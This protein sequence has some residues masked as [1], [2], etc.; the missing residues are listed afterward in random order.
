MEV[1]MKKTN[2]KLFL[3]CAG[4]VT[5]GLSIL[6]PGIFIDDVQAF[7]A[8][9]NRLNINGYAR[10]SV[11]VN[12]SDTAETSEDDRFDLGM[13]RSTLFVDSSL[14]MDWIRFVTVLRADLEY[15]T[16]YLRRLDDLSTADIMREYD[17][18]D[19]REY[20]VDIPI[21]NRVSAR[22]GKQIVSWGRVDFFRAMDRVHGEDWTWRS[23]LP[24]KEEIKKPLIM[25]NIEIQVPELDGSLQILI[26]PGLDRNRDNGDTLDLFGGRWTNQ[27]NRGNNFYDVLSYNY[28]FSDGDMDDVTGGIRWNGIIGPVEYSL[29]YLRT[30][31]PEVVV[32][33]NPVGLGIVFDPLIFGAANFY[34]EAP[35]EGFF[36]DLVYPEQDVLG[37]TA[38]YY[39]NWLDLLARTEVVYIADR[40]YQVGTSYPIPG[41][42]G[43]EEKDTLITMFAVEKNLGFLQGL[44]GCREQPLLLAQYYDIWI[45]DYDRDDD[46]VYRLGNASPAREH[47]PNLTLAISWTYLNGRVKPGIAWVGDLRQGGGLILPSLN[48][49]YGDHWRLR[50]EADIFYDRGSTMPG[51]T[52]SNTYIFGLFENSDQFYMAL[53]YQF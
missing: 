16:D 48:F 29:N 3:L 31:G 34:K 41:M 44:L 11:A 53:E 36:G 25:A 18:F 20:Y 46:I 15:Q 13:V 23:F 42:L 10:Q 19:V 1:R 32:N 17:E 14:D 21:G 26:K 2:H 28:D 51:E 33:P 5:I 8:F 24:S 52:G 50:L 47:D 43:V 45:L 40:P 37:V 22:L 35:E 39:S 6:L 12:L 49:E 7:S 27:P 38:N 9:D 30:H 4:V